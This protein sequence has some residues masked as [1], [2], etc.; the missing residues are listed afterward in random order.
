M[1]ISNAFS[2]NDDGKNDSPVEYP[3]EADLIAVW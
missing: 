1:Y 2:S 3:P